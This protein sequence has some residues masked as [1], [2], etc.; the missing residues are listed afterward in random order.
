MH[1]HTH[2]CMHVHNT[3]ILAHIETYRHT[4]SRYIQIHT[5]VHRDI[6]YAHMY[7]HRC[8]YMNTQ[9]C[10]H[11]KDTHSPTHEH[12]HRCMHTN[13]CT[14]RSTH[15]HIYMH[16][17]THVSTPKVFIY[18]PSFNDNNYPVTVPSWTLVSPPLKHFR[19]SLSYQCKPQAFPHKG[20][21]EEPRPLDLRLPCVDA[22]ACR[23]TAEF[24]PCPCVVFFASWRP[25][26]WL[27]VVS[28]T[29]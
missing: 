6:H 13:T 10:T 19:A 14:Y 22:V 8:T 11:Y 5:C 24:N 18:A 1:M 16:A 9:R 7:T 28:E 17:H 12:I 25:L 15:T 29:L 23:H 2:T 27:Q 3:H 4:C 26:D 20:H 21:T